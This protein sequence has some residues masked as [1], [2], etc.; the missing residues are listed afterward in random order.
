[1][2]IQNFKNFQN[3]QNFQNFRIFEKKWKIPSKIFWIDRKNIF[4][5]SWNFFWTS[6][7]TQNLL[8]D[9]MEA[10]SA[11]ENHSGASYKKTYFL[12][13]LFREI[14]IPTF[15]GCSLV[16]VEVPEFVKFHVL[17]T[18]L[19]YAPSLYCRFWLKKMW[20]SLYCR[21]YKVRDSC[22]GT[23]DHSIVSLDKEFLPLG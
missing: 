2:K 20:P 3:F 8:A 22:S 11:S 1:M 12:L 9:R 6:R 23:D 4:R 5:K 17:L 19:L 16:S 15:C 18:K 7:S 14:S 21:D 13:P 10:L